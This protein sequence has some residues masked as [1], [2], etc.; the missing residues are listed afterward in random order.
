MVVFEVIGRLLVAVCPSLHDRGRAKWVG[1]SGSNSRFTLYSPG[2]IAPVWLTGKKVA[3][4]IP[5]ETLSRSAK[6]NGVTQ[7]ICVQ[8]QSW[9][10]CRLWLQ[11]SACPMSG[12]QRVV[13]RGT[14]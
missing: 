10:A 8:P 5:S 9:R 3:G 11:R 12:V 4:F 13:G 6:A 1:V 2:E 14:A 7:P